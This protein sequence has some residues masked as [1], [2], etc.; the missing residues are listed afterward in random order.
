MELSENIKLLYLPNE[1]SQIVK[2][3]IFFN[4]GSMNDEKKHGITHLLEHMILCRNKE[5]NK[6]ELCGGIIEANTSKDNLSISMKVSK[7]YF[8]YTLDL[9][10]III[11]DLKLTYEKFENERSIVLKEIIEH[12]K[13]SRVLWDL[14]S[15]YYWNGNQLQYPVIGNTSSINDIKLEEIISHHKKIFNKMVISI[16]GKVDVNKVA[17]KLEGNLKLFMD[18]FNP[19]LSQSWLPKHEKLII[20]SKVPM[21]HFFIT[22]FIDNADCVDEIALKALSILMTGS[23]GSRSFKT[24]RSKYALSYSFDTKLITYKNF[25][26]YLMYAKCTND[27]EDKIQKM[28]VDDIRNISNDPIFQDELEK[29]KNQYFTS[30]L[31]QFEDKS[32]LVNLYGLEELFSDNFLP[33]ESRLNIIKGLNSEKL[34]GAAT[35]YLNRENII[36]INQ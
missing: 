20:K 8:E 17:I 5:L 3:K 2:F 16:T 10:L 25:A 7:K 22:Y 1:N 9:L 14:Y 34:I 32:S 31:N 6:I 29:V 36:L 4:L 18:K 21:S 35:K 11:I 26:T 12:Q 30:I 24:L 28:I 33:L 13:S 15:Y 19:E 27:N 23:I